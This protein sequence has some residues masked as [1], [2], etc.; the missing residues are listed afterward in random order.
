MRKFAI[1]A[2][3]SMMLAL[4]ATAYAAQVNKYEISGSTSPKTAGS[5]SKPKPIGIKFGFDVTEESGNRPAVVSSYVIKFGGTRVNTSVAGKC[6]S[7]KLE[8]EG[9]K[10]CPSNSIVGTG[11]IKNATGDTA[12]EAAKTIEC[13]A[14]LSV[15]NLGGGKASI[16]VEGSPTA[17]DPRRKCEIQLSAGIPAV[18]KN[19]SSGST[20]TFTV[21][22]SLKH[23]LP[24]LSNAVESVTSSIKKITK[25]GKGFYEA[26]G[27]TGGKRTV[28]VTFKTEAG[29]TSE[30]SKKV[31]CS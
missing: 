31:N 11:F 20:L 24:T 13:N 3:F 7:A 6:S 12:N 1:F 16:F 17:T 8:E 25:K 28:S 29:Q 19:T 9:P 23:P 27:C 10:G 2:A 15:V 18:F 22:A 30:A 14:G 21:P 4:A 26:T 5:K